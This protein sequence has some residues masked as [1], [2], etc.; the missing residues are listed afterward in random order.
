MKKKGFVFIETIV[1][2][3][4]L[5]TSLMI[6]YT[7]F[8]A[9]NNRE[10][11]K[12][13]YDDPVKIYETYYLYRY[14]E[15]FNLNN[16]IESVK[17]DHIP[18]N[19][20]N[21][22]SR[23]LGTEIVSENA[24]YESMRSDLHVNTIYL[25][26]GN[27]SDIT[28]CPKG[29]YP[30]IC[31]NRNL[32]G[33][34]NTLDD[35]DESLYFIV[36]FKH[37]KDGQTCEEKDCFYYYAHYKIAKEVKNVLLTWMVDYNL[38]GGT[39]T[40]ESQ[41]KKNNRPLT[42]SS[43]EPSRT[44]YTFLGWATSSVATEATYHAGD[45]Y[46][47]NKG[48]TLYAVWQINKY[49]LD[50][51]GILDGASS[52]N[53][54]GFGTADVYINDALVASSVTD[55]Y[56]PISYGSRYKI[57]N[58]KA[59]DGHTYNG[60]A[61]ISGTMGTSNVSVDL[62]FTTKSYYLDLN[63]LLDGVSSG[64]I[65]GY[66]TAD[67]YINGTKVA[68]DVT[69]FYQQIKHGSTYEITDI[70]AKNGVAYNGTSQALK[71]TMGAGNVSIVLKYSTTSL[72]LF[73]NGSV[74]GTT[75]TWAGKSDGVDYISFGNTIHYNDNNTSRYGNSL[76][77]FNSEIDITRYKKITVN[78]KVN[79]ISDASSVHPFIVAIFTL[80]PSD[81]RT[82]LEADTGTSPAKN[83]SKASGWSNFYTTG[84]YTC[85]ADISSLT[86]NY[87]FIFWVMSHQYRSGLMNLDITSIVLTA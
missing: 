86:G 46:T 62:N 10:T 38:N 84:T 48:T 29:K 50:L 13:R 31:T 34:L 23:I 55:F 77:G 25:T 73:N 78:F 35:D 45:T 65:S 54:N 18:V 71:G 57:T 5:I 27:I 52:S 36:E 58:I 41:E 53:I 83:L 51:N 67:V 19:V 80:N 7:L 79:S 63:G 61:T 68:D 66:G 8:V 74:Y 3:G 82:N 20:N 26:D 43:I 16:Y 33:Y 14:L 1:V 37:R 60:D 81:Y 87:K 70:K 9:T 2:T 69:D 64:N 56:Q 42:L 21:L 47:D 17:K 39:G 76:I 24:F 28:A 4:F 6:L 75:T 72:Y 40:I 12:L 85:T 32:L 11:R 49:S 15:N 22:T 30:D 44:G 59:T